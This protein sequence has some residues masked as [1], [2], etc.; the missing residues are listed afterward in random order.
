[1][2]DNYSLVNITKIALTGST[3]SGK[4]TALYHLG[5]NLD[6]IRTEVG[7]LHE[8]AM[9]CPYP[10]NENGGFI[11]QHWIMSNHILK[12][13]ELQKRFDIV[14]TDRTVY[15]G[16]AYLQIAKHTRPEIDFSI[17]MAQ[18]W[19]KQFPYNFIF[20]FA[21]LTEVMKP[22]RREYQ[23]KLDMLLRT[24]I[25][26]NIRHDKII[27]VPVMERIKRCEFVT[28]Y[29][30]KIIEEYLNERNGKIKIDTRL[31]E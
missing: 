7:I 23:R 18:E 31:S 2:Y 19:Y 25:S 26:Y 10:R 13:Y 29:I 9:E 3:C 8:R 4:T 14:I 27:Y 15:D 1:M 6:N 5:L 20:Y 22:E 12:E 11:T 24:T 30:K 16:I 28:S 21:P 17:F